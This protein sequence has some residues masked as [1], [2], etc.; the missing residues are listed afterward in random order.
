MVAPVETGSPKTRS[1]GF[2]IPEGRFQQIFQKKKF[3][4]FLMFIGK[5]GYDAPRPAL[6]VLKPLIGGRGVHDPSKVDEGYGT[7]CRPS[8]GMVPLDGGRGVWYPSS[9][10]EGYDTPRRWTWGKVPLVHLRGVWSM[11]R[12][13]GFILALR[14]FSKY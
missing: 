2:G 8:R 14:Y 4:K 10:L 7:P 13:G 9:S 6:R 1:D 12:I 11:G 3:L 5:G